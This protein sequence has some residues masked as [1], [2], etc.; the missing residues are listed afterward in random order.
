[1]PL[2][3]LKIKMGS[4]PT[5]PS[6]IPVIYVEGD[7]M[8][9]YVDADQQIK[10]GK[11]EQE[12]LRPEIMEIALAEIFLRSCK[13]PV[14]PTPTVMLQDDEGDQVQVQFTKS[15]KEIADVKAAER[16]FKKEL[17]DKDG[18][19]IDINDYVQECVV[20]SIDNKFFYDGDGKFD[21]NLYE[22]CRR[23]LQ[24][25]AAKHEKDNPL[26]TAKVVKPLEKFHV[27]R[28]TL[29]PTP[30]QQAAIFD[31]IPNT[32]RLVPV[33]RETEEKGK[34]AAAK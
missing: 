33:T 10:D 23:A 25:I 6:A 29:A 11:A 26:Q 1:M 28:F 5:T 3:R 16:L 22:E 32:V 9:K 18:K 2:K 20:A 34:K 15:Y 30:L 13:S 27:E 31:I 14:S 17:R 24:V 8:K 4:K 12:E 19:P 21:E 7:Q